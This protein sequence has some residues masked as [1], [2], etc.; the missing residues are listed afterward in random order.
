[1]MKFL[2][3]V[4]PGANPGGDASNRQFLEDENERLADEMSHKVSALRSV[5]HYV[6][7]FT[8]SIA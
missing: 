8:M 4:N 2:L 3:T 1:M 5:Y 6:I 7:V